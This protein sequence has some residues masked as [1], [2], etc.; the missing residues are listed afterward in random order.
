MK[1]LIVPSIL[2]A[3]ALGACGSDGSATGGP[4][5]KLSDW[6]MQMGGNLGATIA[7]LKS[8]ATSPGTHAPADLAEVARVPASV[9]GGVDIGAE[10]SGKMGDA[11]ADID[12]LGVEET[13]TSFVPDP[14][15]N[16]GTTASLPSFVMWRGDVETSDASLCYLAWTK[17]ASWFVVSR[18][19]DRSGAWVCQVTSEEAV[20]NACSEVGDCQPCDMEQ[21]EFTCRW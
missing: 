5:R 7:R 20:C 21:A 16:A 19:G 6:Y 17:G 14:P 12:G 1:R 4:S 8:S 9:T 18:C 13:V 3:L 2:L 10:Q 11:T 15:S